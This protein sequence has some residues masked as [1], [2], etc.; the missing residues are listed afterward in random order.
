MP[1]S[2]LRAKYLN[3]IPIFLGLIIRL[4]NIQ[5]PIVGVH[6]WRQSDTAAMA[7]HFALENTPIWLPQIDWGGAMKGYVE[8]E[9]PIYPFIVGQFYKIFGL[10]E[11]FGRLISILF[12]LLTILLIIRITSILFNDRAGFWA[13]IFYALMPLSVYYSRTFQA[14]SLL[15]FLASLSLERFLIY[16]RKSTFLSIFISWISF[17]LACLIKVLPFIWI[18]LP[19][20]FISNYKNKDFK[21]KSIEIFSRRIVKNLLSRGSLIYISFALFFLILWYLYSYKLGV[22]GGHSFG[23][24][25]KSSDRGSVELIFS[26]QVWLNLLLRILLRNLSLFGLPLLIIAFYKN[27]DYFAINLLL[28][29]LIGVFITTVLS[30]RSSSIHEYYQLPLQLYFCPL[31]GYGMYKIESSYSSFY[32]KKYLG[33]IIIILITLVSAIVLHYDYFLIENRQIKI[34]MPLANEI[35]KTVPIDGKIVS[36][37]GNDPTLLNLSRRQGWLTTIDKI[38]ETS[39]IS[40]SENGASYVVG[41]L[42]W[43]DFY[44]RLDEENAKS[45]ITKYLCRVKAP[46]SCPSSPNNIYMIPLDEFKK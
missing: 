15:L 1:L 6:S 23:F 40:W 25:G 33:K 34:W 13:G 30:M 8:S 22:A 27:R 19:L 29:G 14:E 28:S 7:R 10:N 11:I 12:G 42:N 21:N 16:K 32:L 20:F 37:T 38:D 3:L 39:L 9:F 35:R 18:G 17:T 43:I 26:I 24:W 4:V 5:I 44:N 45:K 41:S 46:Y 36:V 2:I 31:M